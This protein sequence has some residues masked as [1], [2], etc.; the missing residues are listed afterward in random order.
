MEALQNIERIR[1]TMRGF[2]IAKGKLGN[3]IVAAMK[4]IATLEA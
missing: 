4:S 2:K 3:A 1:P